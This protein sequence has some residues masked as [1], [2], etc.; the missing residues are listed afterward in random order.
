MW[1]N[2]A[3]VGH[4]PLSI[5]A[6]GLVYPPPPPE[7]RISARLNTALWLEL[8]SDLTPSSPGSVNLYPAFADWQLSWRCPSCMVTTTPTEKTIDKQAITTMAF[9]CGQPT[10]TKHIRTT[11]AG[12]VPNNRHRVHCS[13]SS[14]RLTPFRAYHDGPTQSEAACNAS[15]SVSTHRKPLHRVIIVRTH[16]RRALR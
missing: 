6:S 9:T 8:L 3:N 10:N 15:P 11:I 5:V 1:F 2:Q 4:F 14:Q 16:G 12:A 13:E 7:A